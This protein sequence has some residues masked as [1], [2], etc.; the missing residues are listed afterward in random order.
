MP[1]YKKKDVFF[2]VLAFNISKQIC[3]MCGRRERHPY[4]ISTREC[5]DVSLDFNVKLILS[6]PRSRRFFRF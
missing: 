6:L 3:N 2:Y 1:I 5:S 4:A